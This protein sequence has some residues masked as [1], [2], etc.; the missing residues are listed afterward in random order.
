MLPR[1]SGLFPLV[2]ALELVGVPNRP[3]SGGP[4]DRRHARL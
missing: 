1:F 2:V 3:H 4:E